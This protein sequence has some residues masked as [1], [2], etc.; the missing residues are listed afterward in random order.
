MTKI[1]KIV[2]LPGTGKTTKL[3]EILEDMFENR[4]VGT[5]EVIYS[6][7]SRSTSKAIFDKMSKLGY[8]RDV[9]PYFRTLH[10]LAARV[11]DLKQ[12]ESFVAENDYKLFC[13]EHG[14]SLGQIKSK[15]IDEIEQYGVVGKEYVLDVG[16]I[17]FGWWQYLKKKYV[18][19]KEVKNV[20][21]ERKELSILEQQTLEIIPTELILDWY[22]QWEGYK[23]N[24]GKYEYDD[25]LQEIVEQE[26][27]FMGDIRY[28]VVDES[29]DLNL[30]QFEM[31]KL[32]I[33]QCE[34]VYFAGD[35]CQAIYFFNAADPTL[36]DRLEGEKARLP[37]SYR[38]PRIPWDY[39]KSI[40]HLI[41]EHDIDNVDPADKE[42]DVLPIEWDDVFRILPE[43]ADKTTYM[44]F[45]THKDIGRFL[46]RSFRERLFV[47]GFGRT[48]TFL[49]NPFFNSTY[50]LFRC[51][52]E[53]TSPNAEDIRRFILRLPA[54]YLNR[55]IKTKVRRGELDKKFQ[56]KHLLDYG[57]DGGAENFYSLFRKADD[58]AGIVE[59]ISNT[60]VRLPNK[61][62]FL[63]YPF[64][65]VQMLNNVFVGTY[66]AS[67]GLEADRIFLFDYFPHKEANIRRD[68]C[69]IVF[70]G[71]TRT[72][73]V[74]YIV[75]TDYKSDYSYGHGLINSLVAGDRRWI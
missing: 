43:Q 75:T 44:L 5:D 22:Y 51:L 27:P 66:F 21:R 12:N 61:S 54:K 60:K 53:G 32:W 39:A 65:K 59:I 33:P 11:L 6:S 64:N 31:L 37:R 45:R 35:P 8:N 10:A 58:M 46:S 69:R 29:Q 47:K 28:I 56:Q 57:G 1:H 73:D 41:G 68:E 40:S 2:G 38:V 67:K 50:N 20:I 25:M 17:L 48:K 13:V 71:F 14:I 9:L 7:F 24:F 49:N 30:L 63:D 72:L 26:I 4:G 19:P 3:S 23:K 74:D 52:E 15:T 36:I 16:N 34:E 18:H 55:G 42:G 62:L 70:T